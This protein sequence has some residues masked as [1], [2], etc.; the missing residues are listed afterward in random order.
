MKTGTIKSGLMYTTVAIYRSLCFA[1][2]L[3]TNSNKSLKGKLK[4]TAKRT[5]VLSRRTL[6]LRFGT[7]LVP[8]QCKVRLNRRHTRHRGTYNERVARGLL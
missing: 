5:D 3:D 6:V 2:E 1:I 7:P 4:G 8:S